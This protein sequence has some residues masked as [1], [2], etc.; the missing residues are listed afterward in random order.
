MSEVVTES[1][2][3]NNLVVDVTCVNNSYWGPASVVGSILKRGNPEA[4]QIG[5]LFFSSA[6]FCPSSTTEE[7]LSVTDEVN[8]IMVRHGELLANQGL[9]FEDVVKATTFYDGAGS[10][11]ALHENMSARNAFYNVPGPGSTG[12]PVSGFP[13]RDVRTSIELIASSQVDCSW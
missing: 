12:L 4:I 9:G 8:S 1:S 11:D 5:P 7:S 6:L 3:E 2:S 10:A 13:Y